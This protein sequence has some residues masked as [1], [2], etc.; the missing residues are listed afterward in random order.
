M[1]KK[2]PPSALF[3][4]SLCIFLPYAHLHT[5]WIHQVLVVVVSS[6][7]IKRA[8]AFRYVKTRRKNY[9]CFLF[10]K[11]SIFY[12]KELCNQPT[13]R[14]RRQ[15]R[16]RIFFG[17]LFIFILSL[18]SISQLKSLNVRILLL[19]R[20]PRGFLQSRKHRVW[21]PGNVD[22]KNFSLFFL[23]KLFNWIRI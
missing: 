16:C 12:E 1:H 2:L 20:D 5:F 3:S 13:K 9:I 14:R 17:F 19:I 22:C 7:Y 18:S 21:C 4:L 8:L 6:T 23:H 11:L 10:S 15:R